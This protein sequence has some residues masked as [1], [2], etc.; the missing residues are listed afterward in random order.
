M[1]P[2]QDC[3]KT[4]YSH[5]LVSAGDCFQDPCRY[6]KSEDAQ[7]PYIK[8]RSIIGPLDLQVLHF[9]IEVTTNQDPIKIIRGG[10]K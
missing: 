6:Q 10:N 7:V 4:K 9:G 3:C 8:W 2:S 1:C 5:P